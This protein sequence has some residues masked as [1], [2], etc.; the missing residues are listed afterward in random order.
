MSASEGIYDRLAPGGTGG[1]LSG[2]CGP[3]SG[4]ADAMKRWAARFDPLGG[5]TAHGDPDLTRQMRWLPPGT[6][7]RPCQASQVRYGVAQWCTQPGGHPGGK[8]QVADGSTFVDEA[9]QVS[10]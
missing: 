4:Q 3:Y 8:H 9:Q 6:V 10:Q 1:W 2:A 7:P 5:G